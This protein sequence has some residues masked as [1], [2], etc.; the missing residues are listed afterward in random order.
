MTPLWC[1]FVYR[2]K[3]LTKD[4]MLVG[5]LSTAF[6]LVS[7]LGAVPAHATKNNL[8][9]QEAIA[10]ATLEVAFVLSEEKN[11]KMLTKYENIIDSLFYTE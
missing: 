4:K 7:I 6:V 9:K 1:H 11:N 2:R 3:N 8:S 5:V 10:P